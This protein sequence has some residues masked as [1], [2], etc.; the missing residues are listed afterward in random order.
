MT[1]NFT[2]PRHLALSL[3][4]LCLSWGAWAEPAVIPPTTVVPPETPSQPRA[5]VVLPINTLVEVTPAEEITSKH[6]KEGTM[7][8]FLVARD[9]VEQG[10]VVIPRGSP[11]RAEVTWRT[12]RG[13]VGKS[14][15]FELTFRAVTVDGVERALRGVHRQEGRGNTA[16]ALLGATIITGR[17]ASMTPGQIINVFTA[18]PIPAP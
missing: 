4:G 6:M 15:K 16:G 13:I 5:K 7:R 10:T 14:G 1:K 11:V 12:G 9:V 2:T 3:M 8:P 18:E 17:S